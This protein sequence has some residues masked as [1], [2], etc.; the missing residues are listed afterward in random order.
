MSVC[1]YTPEEG[2]RGKTTQVHLVF[3]AT[4]ILGEGVRFVQRY[5]SGPGIDIL[6]RLLAQYRAEVWPSYRGVRV[7]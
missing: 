3:D 5:K 1:A 6:I 7:G 4:E 2:G